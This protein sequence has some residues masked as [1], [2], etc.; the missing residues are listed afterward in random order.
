M[1]RPETV[2]RP[3]LTNLLE[4]GLGRKL[5][6]LSAPAGS[7]K[8][9]LLAE[10]HSTRAG[11]TFP[12]AWV[13]LD[14]SDNDPV[15]FWRYVITALRTLSPSVGEESLAELATAQPAPI[16]AIL[17]SLINSVLEELNTDFALVLDDYHFIKLASIH[18]G[19]AYLLQ[20]MPSNMHLVIAT[21]TD[22]IELPLP[23]YR[24]RREMVEIRSEELRF[25]LEDATTFF[26][27]VL[28]VSLK[29]AEIETLQERTEGWAA[30]LQLAALSLQGHKDPAVFLRFFSGSQPLVLDYLADEVL[31]HQSEPVKEFLLHTAF[32][33]QLNEGLAQAV[34]GQP[35]SREMLEKLDR[36]NLFVS[37]L[38]LTSEW[39][40]YHPLFAEFLVSLLKRTA[41]QKLV[42]L[43]R[44]A[45]SWYQANGFE[46]EALTHNLEGRDYSKVVELLNNLVLPL[47]HQGQ[48][49]TVMGWFEALPEDILNQ[50]PRLY[51][52]FATALM[53][54]NRFDKMETLL[55]QA[56][57]S[58]RQ[59]GDVDGLAYP[60]ALRSLLFLVRG[61]TETAKTMARLILDMALAENDLSHM[62]ACVTMGSA[63]LLEG[64]V[65]EAESWLNRGTHPWVE[66]QIRNMLAEAS[67]L[68]GNLSE[69]LQQS[70]DLLAQATMMTWQKGFARVRLASIYYEW[71]RLDE[72]RYWVDQ[73]IS[74]SHDQQQ[75]AYLPEACLVLAWIE[76]A[77]R[78]WPLA[79][80]TLD[81]AAQAAQRLKNPSL[82]AKVEAWRNWFLLLI[83]KETGRVWKWVEEQK[84]LQLSPDQLIFQQERHYLTLVRVLIARGLLDEAL[85]RLDWLVRFAREQGR[86]TSLVEILGLKALALEAS[87]Q[88]EAAL[89]A[90]AESL[91]LAV[92]AGIIRF[93]LDEGIPMQ[94][95]LIQLN[96]IKPN[97]DFLEKLLKEFDNL[98]PDSAK[99]P[100]AQELKSQSETNAPRLPNLPVGTRRVNNLPSIETLSERELEVLR[101]IGEGISNKAIAARLSLSPA[102]VK[103]HINHLYSKLGVE[104][105]VQALDRAKA[106]NLL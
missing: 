22:P 37:R 58:Y 21:R 103:T 9:T 26:E 85:L 95:L 68:R 70:N 33:G 91:D 27:K 41:P 17:T 63:Y 101:L 4:K 16:E 8:T 14:E 43:H 59:Q 36:A 42:E 18:T 32:L 89:T 44:R 88:K 57:N 75:S 86:V 28:D 64:A 5:T 1:S 29:P 83:D 56:E 71:N 35:D 76:W 77:E 10:W 84:I 106:L 51:S 98:P 104:N 61:E 3:R 45:A 39:Y 19:L 102:T 48:S 82:K 23:R 60:L 92:P 69:A 47:V 67:F 100:S 25:T 87:S 49:V 78:K 24:V 12:L 11:S 66:L 30:G 62:I 15:R 54:A 94:K 7:G 81:K 93:F 80:Q 99:I 55:E 65:E 40:R 52:L 72:A 96:I 105:R 34:S 20:H 50:N 73:A 38:E 90:L 2:L 6:L 97:F 31:F 79:F 46:I 74:R 53:M 13:S